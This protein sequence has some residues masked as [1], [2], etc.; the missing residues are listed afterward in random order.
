MYS[1][2]MLTFKLRLKMHTKV[3]ILNLQML[4]LQNWAQ[5]HTK[6]FLVENDTLQ[7]RRR[8]SPFCQ[9]SLSS[10]QILPQL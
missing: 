10:G 2:Q 6:A 5:L 3:I 8:V 9:R 7:E 1:S 4:S